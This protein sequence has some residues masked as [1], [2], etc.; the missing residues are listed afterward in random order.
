MLLWWVSLGLLAA[1]AGQGASTGKTIPSV[2]ELKALS[3]EQLLEVPIPVVS[4]ASKR[5]QL[6]SEAPAS[7]SVVTRE[8]IQQFGYRTLADILASVRGYYVTSDRS[9][10]FLGVRG[11]NW[12]GSYGGRTLLLVDGHRMNDPVYGTAAIG[13]DFPVDVDLIDHVEVARGPGG[14]LY[15][16][17]AFLTVIN[18]VTRRGRDLDGAEVSGAAGSYDSYTGR[19]SYG[20]RFKND[21]EVLLS[22]T[23]LDRDGHERLSYPEFRGSNGGRAEHLDGELA[24]SAFLSLGYHDFT[25]TGVWGY[26]EKDIPTAQFA[27]IFNDPRFWVSDERSFLELKYTH[28]FAD[29]WN[30]LGRLYLDNYRYQGEYPYEQATAPYSYLNV[31]DINATWWG[32]EF[33]VSRTFFERHKLILGTEFNLGL[34]VQQHNF[35][36]NPRA[37][38]ANVDSHN[39]N[40]G[41]YLQDEFQVLTN[42]VLNASLR[43]DEYETFGGQLNLRGG[44]IYSPFSTTTLKLVYGQGYRSPNAYERDYTDGVYLSNTKLHPEEIKSYEF[45]WEQGLSSHLRMTGDLFYNQLQEVITQE[46]D[47][48]NFIFRNA[49]ST[50]MAGG[51][52]ELQGRWARGWRGHLSYTYAHVED[53]A[54]DERIPDSPTHLAKLGVVMP[55]WQ[56]TVFASMEVQAMSRRRGYD[57]KASS[58][59]HAVVNT[60]L[61]SR[62]LVKGLDV[63]VSIYNLFNTGFDDPVGGEFAQATIPQD[64][65]SYRLKLTWRY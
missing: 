12:A 57:G 63:S 33:N 25:L 43:Y 39:D 49:D 38:V 51:E 56:E 15:G 9:Y 52:V 46:S 20:K 1:P 28:E 59:G 47:G 62:E 23:L 18:V 34:E 58:D 55:V 7:V 32:G 24:Q 30:C 61:F 37:V 27:T 53:N 21:V 60:T 5:E 4:G 64:G 17:N 54:T 13:Y 35:D 26:R 22:G 19:T 8:D 10:S 48:G 31:D 11:G 16:D 41:V 65:R 45:I 36:R 6:A 14:S 3:L 2:A 44:L 50:D 42:L 29:D 40:V